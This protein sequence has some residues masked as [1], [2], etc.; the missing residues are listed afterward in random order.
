MFPISGLCRDTERATRTGT[1][2]SV[3]SLAPRMT[4]K[5]LPPCQL[6]PRR[7]MS[8]DCGAPLSLCCRNSRKRGPGGS[9]HLT[10]IWRSMYPNTRPVGTSAPGPKPWYINFDVNF[11]YQLM[12]LCS[13]DWLWRKWSCNSSVLV[14]P[15]V[16]SPITTFIVFWG[17]AEYSGMFLSVDEIFTSG[18]QC[19]HTNKDW[20]S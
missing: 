5:F 6:C 14:C 16:V 13:P 3:R 1:P 2:L 12:S 9:T 20:G 7:T 4:W 8:W 11:L 10:V 17:W 19:R 18:K 15:L